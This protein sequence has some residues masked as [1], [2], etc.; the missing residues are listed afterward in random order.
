MGVRNVINNNNFVPIKKQ[1]RIMETISRK[2]FR[3]EKIW[4]MN[5]LNQGSRLVDKQLK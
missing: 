2:Y 4:I 5:L 1:S 3:K